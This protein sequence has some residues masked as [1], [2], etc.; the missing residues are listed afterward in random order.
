MKKI[1]VVIA[2]LI[3]ATSVPV[4]AN[5]AQNARDIMTESWGATLTALKPKASMSCLKYTTTA[6]D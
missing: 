1:F 2:L 4:F 5:D 6:K 3:I